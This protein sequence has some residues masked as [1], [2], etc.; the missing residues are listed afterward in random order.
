MPTP[1]G[2]SWTDIAARQM[3]RTQSVLDLSTLQPGDRVLVG[4][5]NTHYLLEWGGGGGVTVSTN[6]KDR[7]FGRIVIDGCAARRLGDPSPGV[8]FCGG[9]MQYHSMNGQVRHRTTEIQALLVMRAGGI[10]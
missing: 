5:R 4:T 1:D 6:R 3:A 10:A 9:R 8:L 7:P 2:S